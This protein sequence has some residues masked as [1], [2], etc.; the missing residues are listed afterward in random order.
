MQVG[1]Y[2]NKFKNLFELKDEKPLI[3]S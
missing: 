3:S 1:S 2:D